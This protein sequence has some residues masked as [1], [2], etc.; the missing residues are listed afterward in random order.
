MFIIRPHKNDKY[1]FEIVTVNQKGDVSVWAILLKDFLYDANVKNAEG[2]SLAL[3][4]G[5]EFE[6]ELIIKE[7]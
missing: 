6:C 7:A 2:L 1:I 4:A 5:E 3:K